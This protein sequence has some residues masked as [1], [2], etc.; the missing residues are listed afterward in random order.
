MKYD[1]F[2]QLAKEAGIEEAELFIKQSYSLE[3]SVFHGEVEN[4][5]NNN[6]FSIFARGLVNGKFGTVF[7]D[8]YDNKKAEF[9][10][11]EIINNAKVIENKDPQF[12]FGGSPKY[13]RVSTF[14][15]QLADISIEEKMNKL[16]ELEKLIK[17]G[18]KRISEV[19]S[20]DYEEAMTTVTLMNSKGLK[21]VDKS[22]YFMYVGSAV[23]K[24]KDAV[25]SGYEVFLDNDFSKLNIKDLA[26]K[27]V[28]N[29]VS[30]LGGEPCES[31]TYKAVLS[32]E[33]LSSLLGFYISNAS[34]EDV[35]KNSSLFKDQLNKQIASKKLTVEDRPLTK[36]LFAR[37]FDDEGVATYNKPIIKNGVLMTY[38]YNLTTAA[39]DG[40]ESTG[41]GSRAGS[42]MSAEPHF[43]WVKP[44]KRSKEEL[45]E[46]IK[47]GVYITEVSGLHAGMNA[48]SG[49]FSLQ[50]SG[51]L[52][53]D[54]KKERP[55][56]IITISGNLI[57]VFKDIVEVGKDEQTFIAS[58]S[59]PSV[60]IKK[61][62]VSGK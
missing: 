62:K 46:K 17:D 50:S 10:V 13:K 4:Y 8:V 16:F 5:S 2:F 6:A 56:D 26:N 51:F 29:T 42:K 21:L 55:L 44:G 39:K 45:F 12:I 1:K 54:G 24:D 53:K 23:A 40:V 31:K 49:N 35:Q 36:S 32:R 14:N 33:V 20:V 19:Q 38:L 25:K 58:V 43:L 34:A 61:L 57:D 27:V 9:L 18:D 47:D 60:L 37:A 22:N 7:A 3:I 28:E 52:I 15:K 48:R 11:K 59:C 41:N 30:Q